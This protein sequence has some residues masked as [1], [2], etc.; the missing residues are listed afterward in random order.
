MNKSYTSQ[1][2]FSFL[3]MV[4]IILT[5]PTVRILYS[6]SRDIYRIIENKLRVFNQIIQYVNEYYYEDVD[7][8]KTWNGAFHGFM[9]KLDPH[10]GITIFKRT[11]D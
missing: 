4:I 11:L 10:S 3:T 9:E 8:D 6:E 2:K 5:I 7:M 1:V